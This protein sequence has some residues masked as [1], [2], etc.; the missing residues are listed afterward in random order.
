MKV[1]KHGEVEARDVSEM[2]IFAGKVTQQTF[3]DGA[4]T[5]SYRFTVVSFHAGASNKFHAHTCDQI[6]LGTDGM[7]FVAT[8][9]EEFA[10]ERGDV[11]FIPAGEKHRHG[12]R[13]ESDFSHV[14][15]TTP[16]GQTTVLG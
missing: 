16:D 12:A 14:S 11:A 10:M 13:P 4:T 5:E 15:L 3:V 1:M 9:G 7:G 2:P 6:L 8:E